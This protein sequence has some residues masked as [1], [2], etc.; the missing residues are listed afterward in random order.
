MKKVRLLPEAETEIDEAI[1]WYDRQ[2]FGV[3]ERFLQAVREA[4]Q[5]VAEHPHRYPVVATLR[6]GDMV[7]RILLTRFPYAVVYHVG[8]TEVIVIA[9]AHGAQRP[10]YWR[11]RM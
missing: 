10:G 2:E 7:R 4:L 6:S 11:G 3:G 1:Q 9:I 8:E 5:A